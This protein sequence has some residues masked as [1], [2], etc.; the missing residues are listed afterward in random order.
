MAVLL[1]TSGTTGIAKGVMLSHWNLAFDLM[2]APTILNVNT[3]D[4]FFSVLPVHHTYECTCAFLMP[5]YK[6]AAI[7]YCQGLKYITKNL[8]EVKPT[9]LL[10]VPV[11][12]KYSAEECA[13]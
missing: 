7:A 10:G 2:S 5:L 4:I 11:F 12:W 8:E 1:Y 13:Y 9:M 3:W 6:G